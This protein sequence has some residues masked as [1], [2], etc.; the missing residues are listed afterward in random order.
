[1]HARAHTHTQH[2]FLYISLKKLGP[3]CFIQ[4]YTDVT[5]PS[6]EIFFPIILPYKK[7]AGCLWA[8]SLMNAAICPLVTTEGSM[9]FGQRYKIDPLVERSWNS[10]KL[11]F[12]SKQY[13]HLFKVVF[14]FY[15]TW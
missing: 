8:T 15:G 2:P 14:D 6:S 4:C 7:R 13:E 3:K 9:S 11:E 1:M 12:T 5:L 10:I